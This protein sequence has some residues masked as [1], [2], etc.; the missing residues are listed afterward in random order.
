M[1]PTRG[2]PTA[3][4]GE[5]PTLLRVRLGERG[6]VVDHTFG[7]RDHLGTLGHPPTPLSLPYGVREV[8]SPAPVQCDQRRPIPPHF[9][10]FS[11]A[12]DVDNVCGHLG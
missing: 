3:E 11:S 12:G 8:L 7:L 1:L 2:A 9:L 4:L 10:P 6:D 5:R